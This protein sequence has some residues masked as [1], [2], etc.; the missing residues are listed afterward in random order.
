MKK[1]LPII[2]LAS[3]SVLADTANITWTAPTERENNVLLPQSEIASY[4]LYLN[5]V[6]IVKGIPT[7]AS[8]YTVEITGDSVLNMT[9]V[10]TDGRESVPSPDLFISGKGLPGYPTVEV[11]VTIKVNTNAA[12]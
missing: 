8:T 4:N 1:L 6:L 9:T 5:K 2:L 3:F 10:D 7:I 11:T 12:R